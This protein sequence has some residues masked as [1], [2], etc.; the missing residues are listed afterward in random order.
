MIDIEIEL[1]PYYDFVDDSDDSHS[2]LLPNSPSMKPI[3][4][5]K[6]MNLYSRKPKKCNSFLGYSPKLEQLSIQLSSPLQY[7][8]LEG[9][10]RLHKLNYLNVNFYTKLSAER[11]H[12]LWSNVSRMTKLTE[13][14]VTSDY[15]C[16]VSRLCASLPY[17][18]QVKL[19]IGGRCIGLESIAT[20]RNLSKFEIRICGIASFDNVN[21]FLD[22][23]LKV[24]SI[25]NNLLTVSLLLPIRNRA[26]LA[27]T[28]EE[29]NAD[30]RK[31]LQTTNASKL[32]CIADG[33]T[34]TVSPDEARNLFQLLKNDQKFCEI[35]E[36]MLVGEVD[37]IYDDEI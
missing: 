29:H 13:L 21:R 32:C 28:I 25:R 37:K 20:L 10:K 34:F 4:N 3:A 30:R 14:E 18:E 23:L 5:L 8:M 2:E 24:R 22:E 11:M 15:G 12:H 19:K 16:N 1:P 27:A 33:R 9:L 35:E 6:S 7:S 17:I 26:K 31:Y 36:V